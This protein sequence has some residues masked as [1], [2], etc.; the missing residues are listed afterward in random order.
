MYKEKFKNLNCYILV[1][2]YELIKKLLSKE[3]TYFLCKKYNI[4]TPKIYFNIKEIYKKNKKFIRKKIFGHTSIGNL[5]I[6]KINSGHF[7]KDCIIQD[8]IEGQ[9]LHF[10]IFN[11]FNGNYLSSCVKQKIAMRAGETDKANI[12]YSK[13]LEK[14]A[15]KISISFKHIGNL[16]CDA[17]RTNDGSIFFIDF[18]PVFGGGYPFT[19]L[20]GLNYIKAAI[21]LRDSKKVNLPKKPK[22]IKISKGISVHAI[23]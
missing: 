19:H 5:Y 4:K 12:I 2:K 3:L 8:F 13:E 9:E 23:N 6:K 22:L 10:D 17:I 20:S 16:D 21:N 18:N 11:D 7:K 1:S 15:K 14:L